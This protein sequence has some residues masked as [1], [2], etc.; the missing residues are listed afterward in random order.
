MARSVDVIYADLLAKKEADE[1]LNALSSTSKVAIWR[2]WLWIF[3]YGSFILETIFD[4][5]KAEVSE[6]LTQLKPH[7]LRWYR[8][9]VLQFQFCFDLIEDSDVFDNGSATD[10]EIEASKIIKYSAVTESTTESRL[11][12]KIATEDA[13]G[14]LAPIPDE[15]YPSFSAYMEEIKDAGVKIT[16]INYLPDILRLQMQ[17]YYD[18]LLLTA[19]GVYIRTGRKP[20]EDALN[21]FMKELPFNGELIL[22]SLVD[23]LQVTEGVK[24]PHLVNAQS[25]WIGAGGISYGN[26]E[27]IAVKKIPTSGYFQ[28]ENFD[29]I[30]YVAYS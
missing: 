9:K 6:A 12:V 16:V 24:I 21:E 2:L 8:N 30:T 14:V 25:K 15:V 17:I 7:T 27:N 22:A 29:N 28:I 20:V 23:K 26:F 4:T 5:H 19:D 18:P 11:I 10:E 1:N 3:A 13:N